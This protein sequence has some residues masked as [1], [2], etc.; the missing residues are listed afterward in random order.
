MLIE[1][2]AIDAWGNA[3]VYTVSDLPERFEVLS[4]GADGEDGG[5]G[6]DRDLKF[7]DQKK[8]SDAEKGEGE[9]LQT[10]LAD[11]FG[12]VFQLDA[13]DHSKPNWRNSDMTIDEVVEKL[14]GG[15]PGVPSDGDKGG[16]GTPADEL[17]SLLDGS[18]FSAKA[19]GFLLKLIGSSKTM[20][21]LGKVMLIEL[22]SNA[23]AILAAQPGP[24]GDMMDV[25]IIERNKVV[26]DDLRS[27]LENEQ[28]VENVGIIYGAGHLKD[29]EYRLGEHL[30][31]E[32]VSDEW[33]TAIEV[34]VED[35][36][37]SPDQVRQ[38]RSMMT[39]AL[40]A[41]LKMMK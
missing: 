11:A 15:K 8:L 19:A 1:G 35:T 2:A 33:V 5:D 34:D 32:F 9:G 24:L 12:L 18:S 3:L 21:T 27:I 37:M 10:Q 41:Q 36:G 31:Y 26:V 30:G 25:L 23:D 16:G 28:D 6:F 7:T 40:Q 29:L 17:F 14:S 38:M 39:K 4:L 20:S 13:M 22:L